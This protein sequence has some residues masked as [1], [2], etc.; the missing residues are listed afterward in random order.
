MLF[1][2]GDKL[3]PSRVK[4]GIFAL[5]PTMDLIALANN[6]DQV[7]V[8]RIN[9]EQVFGIPKKRPEAQ[10]TRLKWKPNGKGIV[11]VGDKGN[12]EAVIQDDF[13]PQD[14]AMAS[15]YW[16]IHILE[17]LYTRSKVS[18][19]ERAPSDVSVGD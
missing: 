9:G 11:M 14:T 19:P 8:F 5:C 3:L 15:C 13:L 1:A 18:Y 6:D 4:D 16:S 7:Q 2:L 17:E 10:V 12:A